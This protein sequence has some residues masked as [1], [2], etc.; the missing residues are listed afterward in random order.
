MKLFSLYEH[1]NIG[2]QNDPY[3]KHALEK[4][5]SGGGINVIIETGTNLG[6]GS[7][8]L[9]AESFKNKNVIIHTIEVN[10]PIFKQAKQ[11]LKKYKK[12]KCHY[13]CSTEI[14]EAI[15]FIETDPAII[16]HEKHPEFF[17]DDVSNPT[18]FYT[19]EIK[20]I[21]KLNSNK[22][23]IKSLLKPKPKESLLRD[24][25][26]SNYEKELL[27]VLDS[28]GGTGKLE[29]NITTNLLSQKDYYLL[30]DDTHHLKHFRSV[31]EIRNNKNWEIIEQDDKMGW[32]LAKHNS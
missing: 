22:R 21:L 18:E 5:A 7:T 27:I 17:I 24:L 14:T 32:L 19:K 28:A 20:G 2:M 10:F 23:Q 1:S 13:G 9:L 6:L 29:F 31:I 26:K 30:L 16:N 11:N 15:L 8:K 12:V 4:L 25:I 3:L